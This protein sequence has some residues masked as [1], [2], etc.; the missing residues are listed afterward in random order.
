MGGTPL[1]WEE[2]LSVGCQ[3]SENLE[4]LAEKVGTLSL[5]VTKKNHCG[6]AK[7][8]RRARLVEVPAGASSGGEP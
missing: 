3:T 1:I 6:A 8:S 4:G 7:R 2:H 5:Q